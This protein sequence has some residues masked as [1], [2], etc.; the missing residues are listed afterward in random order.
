MCARVD[1]EL[2]PNQITRAKV[3]IDDFLYVL[4]TLGAIPVFLIAALTWAAVSLLLGSSVRNDVVDFVTS[5]VV[6]AA[7]VLAAL[8]VEPKLHSVIITITAAASVWGLNKYW[9]HAEESNQ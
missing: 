4:F 8:Y 6:F 3:M 2:R 1:G 9:P 7:L 5:M